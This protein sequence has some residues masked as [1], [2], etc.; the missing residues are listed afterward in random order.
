MVSDWFVLFE[1]DHPFGFGRE[2]VQV[3]IPKK[4]YNIIQNTLHLG[5]HFQGIAICGKDDYI[6]CVLK[7]FGFFHNTFLDF[8]QGQNK[9]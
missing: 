2:K 6:I 4:D 8:A 7:K 5:E 3:S 1:C 9:E